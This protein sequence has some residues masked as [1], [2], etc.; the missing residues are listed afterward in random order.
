VNRLLE[1]LIG[2]AL[3]AELTRSLGDEGPAVQMLADAR[4]GR[5][6]VTLHD[7]PEQPWTVRSLAKVAMM[8]RS[9][10]SERFRDR[11][12]RAPI[13]YLTDLR[14]TRAA[15]L[16]RSTDATV[17]DV[18]RSVGYGSEESLSRAFKA[19]FGDAPSTFRTRPD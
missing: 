11:V 16:L 12:G 8:S 1:S 19:R 3:R 6:L 18:A 5:V 14:L 7:H 17:A 13:S 4:I 10:F 2:D 15:R 9:A